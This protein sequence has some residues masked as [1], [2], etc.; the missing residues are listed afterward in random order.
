MVTKPW[1]G[2][3]CLRP[4]NVHTDSSGRWREVGSISKRFL[5][6]FVWMTPATAI[7]V[8]LTAFEVHFPGEHCLLC[9]KPLNFYCTIAIKNN[10]IC[11]FYAQAIDV[12]TDLKEKDST[13]FSLS[14]F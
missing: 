11:M 2:E 12:K 8:I 7:S 14:V 10:T 4:G 5:F 13:S 9:L 1:T 3:L 6:C